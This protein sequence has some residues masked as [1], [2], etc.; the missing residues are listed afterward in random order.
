M[1]EIELIDIADDLLIVNKTTIDRLFLEKNQNALV[2]YLFYYKTAKW[3]K[4]NPIKASDDYCKKCLHWGTDKLKETKQRLKEMDL[5][6]I[7]K[8]FDKKHKLEGWYVRINY[9]ISDSTIPKTTIPIKPLVDSQEINTNNNKY[10]NTNKNINTN[11]HTPTLEEIK[12]YC[13][14]VRHNKVDYKKFYDYFTEGNWVDSKG[15]KVK[16]WKQKIITWEKNTNDKKE[17]EYEQL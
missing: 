15:N 6:A 8:R 12:D 11:T 5:I 4:H 7:E 2:L 13:L 3:Q 1:E 16:N 9:L 14:N 17:F 10:I